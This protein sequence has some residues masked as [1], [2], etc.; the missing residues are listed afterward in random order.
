MLFA[1]E[2]WN[3]RRPKFAVLDHQR[4]RPQSQHR[5]RRLQQVAVASQH[6]R[7]G[8]VDEQNIQ[9]LQNF[10]SSASR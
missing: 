2:L 5:A 1:V 9:A 3:K 8:I 4:L 6:F 10:S 7:F